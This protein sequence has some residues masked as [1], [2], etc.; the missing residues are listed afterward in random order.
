MN[1]GGEKRW[2]VT[3]IY[4]T[5]KFYW[6]MEKLFTEEDTTLHSLGQYFFGFT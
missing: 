5:F 1:N 4:D 3:V 6:K 2:N